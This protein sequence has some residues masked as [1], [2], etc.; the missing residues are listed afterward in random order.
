MAASPSYVVRTGRADSLDLGVLLGRDSLSTDLAAR[1]SG[2]LAGTGID[3]MLARLDLELLPSR[4]NQATLGPGRLTLGLDRGALDGHAPAGGR[5][6]RGGRQAHRDGRCGGVPSPRGGRPSGGASGPVDRRH[7][8]RRPARGPL[9]AG[10]GRRQRRPRLRRR[11]RDRRRRRRRRPA[12]AAAPRACGPRPARSR[13]TRW[14]CGPTSPRSTAA[15]AWPSVARVDPAADTLRITG[16][17][18]DLTPLALLAGAD[19]VALDSTLLDLTV[20]GPAERRKIEGNADAFRLL[21][22]GNLAERITAR[23]SGTHGQRRASAPSPATFASRAPRPARW[24]CARWISRAATTPW[25]RSRAP[26]P[27]TTTSGSR[28]ALEGT[29]R[30]GTPPGRSSGG[31][32]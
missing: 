8:R 16:R 2:S 19:S 13:W 15:A 9:R 20:T 27:S 22:A 4:V 32:T 29:A 31:S 25:S 30:A 17:A 26:S 24:R 28:W 3:S 11:H 21:Y 7:R 14:C 12:A 1:F 18:G 5:G 23:G 10:R 6:R